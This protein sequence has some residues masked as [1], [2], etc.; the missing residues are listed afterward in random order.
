[1]EMGIVH[2]ADSSESSQLHPSQSA[3]YEWPES[4][5]GHFRPQ[6][7]R[8]RSKAVSWPHLAYLLT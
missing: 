7:S 3:G 4:S 8:K 2:D 6:M 5:S 1:M